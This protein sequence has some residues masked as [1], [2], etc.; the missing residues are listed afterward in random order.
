MLPKRRRPKDRQEVLFRR[1]GETVEGREEVSC[2]EGRLQ[3]PRRVKICTTNHRPI[4][5]PDKAV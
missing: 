2:R 1:A 4:P 3:L 5:V